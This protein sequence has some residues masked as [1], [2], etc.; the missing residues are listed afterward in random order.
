[1]PIQGV[2]RHCGSSAARQL[3][4]YVRRQRGDVKSHARTPHGKVSKLLPSED[5]GFLTTPDGREIYFHRNSVL[6]EAFDKLEI[7][8]EVSFAEEE[9]NRGPQAS[10]VKLAGRHGGI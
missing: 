6:N 5:Y 2:D 1:M 4:D 3:E 9:G 10:T 8:T 7:G